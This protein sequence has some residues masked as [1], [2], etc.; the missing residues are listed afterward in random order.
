VFITNI[1]RKRTRKPSYSIYV[2]G[3]P[4]F[5]VSEEVLSKI[6]LEV[7]REIS[8]KTVEQILTS[9]AMARAKQIAINYI[10]YRPRSAHEVATK[11]TRKGFSSELAKKVVS[12]LQELKMIDDLEFARMFTRD[13]KRHRPLGRALLRRS[14]HAKGIAPHL[15]EQVLYEIVS[16]EDQEH[17]A[18]QL[19]AKHLRIAQHSYGKLDGARQRKRLHDYLLRRGFS[20]DVASKT[21]RAIL[22]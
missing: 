10:S 3:T 5:E 2:E 22:S 12:R 14:L 21:V 20:N 4:A 1:V 8:E 19:A 13:R 6:G 9:E 18:A 16:D 15:V 7:G 11:L 17:A